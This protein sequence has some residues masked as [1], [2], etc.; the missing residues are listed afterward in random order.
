MPFWVLQ[1]IFC[2]VRFTHTTHWY[3]VSLRR[4]FDHTH[5]WVNWNDSF[6]CKNPNL[7]FINLMCYGRRTTENQNKTL[8]NSKP[9]KMK[10]A[11]T[12]HSNNQL[13]TTKAWPTIAWMHYALRIVQ[14][15]QSRVRATAI[16]RIHVTFVSAAFAS[17][18]LS[19]LFSHHK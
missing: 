18:S 14:F 15:N 4:P 1:I 6:C 17:S 10:A 19:S 16:D 7:T 13:I 11:R 5:F 3:I 8:S 12:E 9:T 2:F